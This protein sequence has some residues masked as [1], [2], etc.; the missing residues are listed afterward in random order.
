M[1]LV[2]YFCMWGLAGKRGFNIHA[3]KAEQDTGLLFAGD[4]L[5]FGVSLVPLFFYIPYHAP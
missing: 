1:S 2:I 3:Q 5:S 4:F